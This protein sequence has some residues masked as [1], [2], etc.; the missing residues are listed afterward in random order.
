VPDRSLLISELEKPAHFIYVHPAALGH[1][2]S[3]LS[4]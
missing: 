4:S 2:L 3:A 1:A